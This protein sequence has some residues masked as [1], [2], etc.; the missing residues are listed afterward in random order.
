VGLA[1]HSPA[2][3]KVAATCY[4]I[5]IRQDWIIIYRLALKKALVL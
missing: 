1:L 5:N 4:N 2:R 3:A